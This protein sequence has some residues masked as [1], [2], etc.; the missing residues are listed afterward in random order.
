MLEYERLLYLWRWS[1]MVMI[2]I[3][4]DYIR[5]EWLSQY[6]HHCHTIK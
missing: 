3:N 5:E 2:V 6:I 4:P 1:H